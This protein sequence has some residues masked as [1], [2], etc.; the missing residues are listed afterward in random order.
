[1]TFTII[2]VL[3]FGY[4]VGYIVGVLRGAHEMDIDTIRR[5][6]LKA[7]ESGMRDGIK[8]CAEVSVAM[9][10]QANAEEENNG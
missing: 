10:K 2:A 9:L 5:K 8:L 4:L 3:F 1:M 6:R 7:Y